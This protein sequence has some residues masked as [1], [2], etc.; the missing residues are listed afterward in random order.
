M[1]N[2]ISPIE[3]EQTAVAAGGRGGGAPRRAVRLQLT[4]TFLP[5]LVQGPTSSGKTSLVE[6]LARRTGHTCVVPPPAT[7]HSAQLWGGE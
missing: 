4:A 1:S 3:Y 5:H 7:R 2:M 6:Y